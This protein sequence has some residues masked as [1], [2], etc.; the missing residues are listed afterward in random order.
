MHPNISKHKKS[1]KQEARVALELGGRTQRGS[2]AKDFRKGDVKSIELLI[3][4][5]RTDKDSIS[6][7]KDWLVKIYAESVAYNR[8]PGLS[9]EFNDMPNVVPRDW[10]AIP[11]KTLSF[12]MECYRTTL[13]EDFIMP[14]IYVPPLSFDFSEEETLTLGEVIAEMAAKANRQFTEK[15]ARPW[16]VNDDHDVYSKLD[17]ILESG[18][19]VLRDKIKKDF[20]EK[21]YSCLHF[22]L[23]QGKD[24]DK[25]CLGMLTMRLMDSIKYIISHTERFRGAFRTPLF[26]KDAAKQE[27]LNRGLWKQSTKKE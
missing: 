21:L 5:K 8:I 11:V 9:I 16:A 26:S 23:D 10:V 17:K 15:L 27:L 14:T 12:L 13:A 20:I 22:M 1:Q 24:D 3:E 7:K 25:K 6:I 4:A 2:G 19:D 18:I